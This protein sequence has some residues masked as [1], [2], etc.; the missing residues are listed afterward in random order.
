M[1]GCGGCTK[2]KWRF[3]RTVLYPH[4]TAICNSKW[5]PEVADEA[6]T[7]MVI[8]YGLAALK[9]N[10]AKKVRVGC[11]W[12]F[13]VLF[14]I[15]FFF[16]ACSCFPLFARDLCGPIECVFQP[17]CI[18]LSI[19]KDRGEREHCDCHFPG[20]VYRMVCMAPSLTNRCS[21]PCASDS[22]KCCKKFSFCTGD[23]SN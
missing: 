20:C 3:S 12:W 18:H 15:L 22:I 10:S 1:R 6:I 2:Y 19:A 17:V 8:V 7:R 5:Q 16:L 4:C 13:G 9:V 14:F 23:K 21:Y 11:A